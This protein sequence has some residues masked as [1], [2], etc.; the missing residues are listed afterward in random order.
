MDKFAKLFEFDDIGQVLVII[1]TDDDDQPEVQ[2]K[3]QPDGLGICSFKL[4][5][6]S[7]WGVADNAFRLIDS[8]FAHKKVADITSQLVELH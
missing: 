4:G 7:D 1:D 5:G 3:F 8:D 6:F 2:I